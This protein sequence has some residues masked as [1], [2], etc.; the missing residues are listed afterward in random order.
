MHFRLSAIT[1][2][3]FR[4]IV[5]MMCVMQSKYLKEDVLHFQTVAWGS[6]AKLRECGHS[7]VALLQLRQWTR[8]AGRSIALLMLSAEWLA[9]RGH[10]RKS[11]RVSSSGSR[12]S[13]QCKSAIK[14]ALVIIICRLPKARFKWSSANKVISKETSVDQGDI[15]VS[16]L[17]VNRPE[18]VKSSVILNLNVFFLASRRG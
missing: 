12:Q 15:I 7:L 4:V 5:W 8:S 10:L 9:H 17:C 6:L 13:R 1:S 14:C 18:H 3:A 16:S 11:T 2:Y